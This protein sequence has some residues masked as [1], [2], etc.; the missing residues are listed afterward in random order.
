LNPVIDT[1]QKIM[2]TAVRIFAEQGYGAT[3]LRHI[4]AEAQVNLAAIHYHFG[5]KDELLDAVLAERLGP[6]NQRRLELLAQVETGQAMGPAAVEGI[7]EAFLR[8]AMLV[9]AQNAEF[10]R[11]MGRLIGEGLM[12]AIAR[13]HFFEAGRRFMAA[14]RRA[15]PDLSEQELAWRVHFLIGAMAH[16][17]CRS[18]D[19]RLGKLTTES[20]EMMRELVTFLAAGF[21]APSARAATVTSR[22]K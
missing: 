6:V 2:D 13:K 16:C 9:A 15:L 12:P 14:L 17:L 21:R 4:I 18:P 22:G 5:S 19:E 8:P 20:P 7:L 10:P 1:K 3:S 11:M